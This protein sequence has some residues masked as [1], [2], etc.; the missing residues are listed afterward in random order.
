MPAGNLAHIQD[1]GIDVL[2]LER[3]LK[4]T[5]ARVWNHEPVN[6][7]FKGSS[8]WKDRKGR[9]GFA[10]AVIDGLTYEIGDCVIVRSTGT[11]TNDATCSAISKQSIEVNHGK[12]KGKKEKKGKKLLSD[13]DSDS[14]DELLNPWYARIMYFFE[15]EVCTLPSF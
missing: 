11:S 15:D 9:V 12:K 14:A 5:R 8:I 7:E 4:K 10:S 13:G 6:I 2:A 3:Y 1:G